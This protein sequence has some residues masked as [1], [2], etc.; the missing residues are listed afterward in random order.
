MLS[1]KKAKWAFPLMGIRIKVRK[2]N[3]PGRELS[4]RGGLVWP[5]HMAP[6]I[7]EA[8]LEHPR[9]AIKPRELLSTD[10]IG[11]RWKRHQGC[12]R[13]WLVSN[14]SV[15][16]SVHSSGGH[17]WSESPLR[18]RTGFYESTIAIS[19]QSGE[20]HYL[21]IFFLSPLLLLVCQW[22]KCYIQE[23]F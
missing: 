9:C 8:T 12:A 20:K 18:H 2:W 16:S 13:W 1:R 5:R 21:I 11:T 17:L 22:L 14:S 6:S 23:E 3:S 7:M 19:F 4:Q 10:R 15:H